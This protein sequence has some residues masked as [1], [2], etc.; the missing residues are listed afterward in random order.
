MV[1][2]TKA[3]QSFSG[4]ENL[5]SKLHSVTVEGH[6]FPR[7]S[8]LLDNKNNNNNHNHIYIAPHHAV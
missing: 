8:R 1:L 5:Q 6:V 3:I 2:I 7:V 4:A